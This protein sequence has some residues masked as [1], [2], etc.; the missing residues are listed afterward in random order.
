MQMTSIDKAVCKAIPAGLLATAHLN[1][2]ALSCK[3]QRSAAKVAAVSGTNA[4]GH[5]HC[6]A[7]QKQLVHDLMVAMSRCQVAW[8][9]AVRI[10]AGDVAASNDQLGHHCKV[11][12]V[13]CMMEGCRQGTLFKLQRMQGEGDL[14]VLSLR[15]GSMA[16]LSILWLHIKSLR[17]AAT[18]CNGAIW[19]PLEINKG[20][21]QRGHVDLLLPQWHVA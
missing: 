2:A 20:S 1:M 9:Q 18:L 6:I 11:A 7:C 5:V 15:R 10:Q 3:V 21:W 8:G 4:A 12:C 13:S 17:A 19:Y 14:L 16:L